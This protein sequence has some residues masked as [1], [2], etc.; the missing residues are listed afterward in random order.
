MLG[1]VSDID[2]RLLRVFLAVADAGGVSAAQ[3]ILN[4]GQSTISTQ[5]AAL[6]SRL[7][8]KLCHRGRSGFGLTAK[9][10]RFAEL[11]RVL[12]NTI[13]DFKTEVRS[14]DKRL[15]GSLRIGMIGNTPLSQNARVSEA[16][17]RFR[18]RDEAVRLMIRVCPPAE[19]EEGVLKGDIDIAV[20]YFWHRTPTL[21]FMPLFRERHLAY[22]AEAHPLFHRCGSISLA[23]AA[24]HPWVWR[25]YPLPEARRFFASFGR[26]TAFADNMEAIAMLVLSGHHLGFLPFHF[27]KPMASDG[28]VAPL[29]PTTMHYDVE[30]HAVTRQPPARNTITTVFLEDLLA[31]HQA[32]NPPAR[33]IDQAS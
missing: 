3:S 29:N 22:C 33:S 25:S 9:G 20:G 30:L 18:K 28:L 17:S 12:L 8:Y 26:M 14:L 7:G 32:A 23:E 16:I 24:Q 2:L 1:D 19:L 27:A 31:V 15:V 13:A 6:E 21:D 4:V 10:E 5:L 11:A